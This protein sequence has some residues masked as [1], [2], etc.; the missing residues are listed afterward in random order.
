MA[1]P[2]KIGGS[3]S[4]RRR[5]PATNVSPGSRQIERSIGTGVSSARRSVLK[6]FITS[7][8]LRRGLEHGVEGTDV[9]AVLVGE[10]H[11]ADVFGIDEAEDLLEPVLAVDGCA[12]VDDDRLLAADQQRVHRQ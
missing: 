11:P 3:T 7:V 1:G 10:E 2:S 5:S 8:A 9:V 4:R 6:K 12:G